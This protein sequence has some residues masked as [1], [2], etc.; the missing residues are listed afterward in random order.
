[1]T[2]KR[3]FGAITWRGR[4]NKKQPK[5]WKKNVLI[6][7]WSQ[8]SARDT[9]RKPWET[10]CAWPN[11]PDA[12]KRFGLW[13]EQ[14]SYDGLGNNLSVWRNF[15]YLYP[16]GILNVIECGFWLFRTLASSSDSR[17][18][19]IFHLGIY[20]SSDEDPTCELPALV[21]EWSFCY[22]ARIW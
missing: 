20:G 2:R 18:T 10:P 5:K 12:L 11:R 21:C 4:P 19:Y 7:E 15:H 13:R 17:G 6:C 16:S 14:T 8:E 9:K 3:Y 22:V 1:M